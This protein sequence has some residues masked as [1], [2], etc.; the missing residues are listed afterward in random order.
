MIIIGITGTIGAGK[1]TIVDYLVSKLN[2]KHFSV[3]SYL[4]QEI[5]ER[6]LPVNRD[7]MVL[8]ANDLRARHSPAYII[9]EL[10]KQAAVSGQNCIIESIRTPGEFEMLRTKENFYFLAVDADPKI[11]YDR[12]YQRKSETD[13]ISFEEFLSNEKREMN[14]SDPNKQNLSVC[15]ANADF[16]LSNN[17]R[18]EDL[19]TQLEKILN[20][21][22]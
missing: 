15:I 22:L 11:R 21:I 13:S 9:E 12:I 3:R 10:Y 19:Y 16:T 4:T 17:G 8:V 7:S 2:F 5:E 14:T 1:G 20:Q 6:N 18:M